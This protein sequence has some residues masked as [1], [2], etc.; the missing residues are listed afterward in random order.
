MTEDLP[1]RD[2]RAS[3]AER[4]RVAEV[5]KDAVSEG[6]L[7]LEEFQERLDSAYRARTR[8]ELLPLVRDLPAVADEGPESGQ[9][10]APAPRGTSWKD[11]IGGTAT[12]RWGIALLGGFGRKGHW[13]APR[14]FTGIAVMG[15]GELDLREARFEQREVEIRCFVF[16]GGMNVI[17]PPEVELEVRGI[18]IMGGFDA[19]AG[20]TGVSGAPRV[21]VTGVAVWGGVATE[22]KPTRAE[23]KRL[24]DERRARKADGG[25][26]APSSHLPHQRWH[27][28]E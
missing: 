15:G 28:S 26:T 14:V 13:T 1:V 24:R 22:R 19:G 3:D 9:E 6:R 2:M 17:V 16:M 7:G 18:G 10:P 23:K 21:V 12:S 27:D 5:L 11:R 8:G 25:R 20:G 4:E